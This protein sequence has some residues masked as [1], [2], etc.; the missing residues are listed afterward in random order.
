MG[1]KSIGWWEQIGGLLGG[2]GMIHERNGVH[3]TLSIDFRLK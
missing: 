1:W 2:D 3:T